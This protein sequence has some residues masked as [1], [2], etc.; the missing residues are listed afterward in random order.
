M[1]SD[2]KKRDLYDRYGEE[3]V[4]A[5]DQGGG[6][7]GPGGGHFHHGFP[8][9]GGGM[10]MSDADAQAFFSHFFGHDDPFGG[11]G[12]GGFGGR[13]DP[14]ASLFGGGMPGGMHGMPGGMHG[15]FGGD[16]FGGGFQQRRP[17]PQPK[18]YDA[19]PVGTIVSLTGLQSQP[20]RNGDRGE[21]R[22][23]DPSTGR[24]KVEI[25]DSDEIISVKAGC[26]L[27]HVG[28]SLTGIE[29]QPSLN[30]KQ[31]TI[32]AWNDGK[33]RYS[34]YIMDESRIGNFKPTN[35]VLKTGTV[36]KIVGLNAKPEL[37]ERFGTIKGWIRESNRYDVQLSAQQIVRIKVENI[38]V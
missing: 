9:R 32:I 13:R 31:G 27:Q 37:N 16:P 3:G 25:E 8:G 30:G 21:V 23:Y 20:E 12:G 24:Y 28:V 35:V 2:E 11:M 34:V 18:R 7:G 5:A 1:L 6:G 15:G 22:Q 38:R 14:M 17:R 19:I 36:G 10:G 26:L 4:N 29:S 33:Q